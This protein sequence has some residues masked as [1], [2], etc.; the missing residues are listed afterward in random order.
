MGVLVALNIGRQEE[1]KTHRSPYISFS[2]AVSKS[3]YLSLNLNK[4]SHIITASFRM[5]HW[6]AQSWYLLKCIKTVS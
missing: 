3:F 4:Y 5:F 1:K 6:H 2:L